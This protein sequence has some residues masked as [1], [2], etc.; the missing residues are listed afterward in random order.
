MKNLFRSFVIGILI[1]SQSAS[2]GLP[3]TTAKV[4]GDS[5]DI[6][7]FKYQ[8]PNFTG[9]HTGTTISLGVNGVAGGGTGDATLSVHGVL[10]GNGTSAVNVTGTGTAGQVLTSNGASADPTYQTNTATP[11][12]NALIDSAYDIWQRGTSFTPGNGASVYGADEWYVKNSLGTN[13]VITFSQVTGS[14]NGS[15]YGASVKITTAPTASQANGTEL[16]Q[17]LENANSLPFYGQTASFS[18]NIKAQGNV[19]Q[20]GCQ[21]F[22]ATS[23][24]KLT[25][26]IGTEQT[27]SVNTS[28]FSTCSIS[29]QA[30]GT[31][32]TT[33]GVVGVRV[34]ITGVSSGNTYDLNN[35]FVAEQ[36]IM[37]LGA[38]AAPYARAGNGFAQ[39]LLLCQ[40]YYFSSFFPGTGSGGTGD[41]AAV[42]YANNGLMFN[43]HFPV[44]MRA[45][46]SISIS[47]N[48]VGNQMR[49]TSTGG[50][51]SL[52]SPSFGSSTTQGSIAYIAVSNTPFTAGLSYDFSL[53]A[54][55][56][57]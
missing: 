37:N 27:A 40:R 3:P 11:A 46:P 49:T 35:G 22:Y 55:A 5:S 19:N 31:A 42:A 13:G 10:V 30:M 12:V 18:I 25:T 34:R 48:G 57:I 20:V 33:S 43:F 21:F 47:N 14:L 24:V 9:T 7:T 36:A 29:G 50:T 38:T 1:A 16:Y 2:A 54:D 15:K 4:S 26:S 32:Q 56:G 17:V 23:E 39:E 51:V 52:T 41:L 45:A 28:G 8:F 53:Q 6:T 44:L